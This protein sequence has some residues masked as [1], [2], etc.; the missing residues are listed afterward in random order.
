MY[1]TCIDAIQ[2]KKLQAAIDELDDMTPDHM[3]TMF[4]KQPRNEAVEKWKK[5]QS[6]TVQEVP[7]TLPGK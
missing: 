4:E 1:E 7:S 2:G 5:R 6:M 3:N